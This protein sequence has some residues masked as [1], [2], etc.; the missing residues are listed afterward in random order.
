MN[1]AIAGDGAGQPLVTVL[2]AHLR[3]G[4]NDVEDLSPAT[5]NGEYYANTA[6]RVARDVLAGRYDRAILVCGTGIGVCISA[7]KVPG[8]RA[9]TVREHPILT[10]DR[11]DL[12]EQ[13]RRC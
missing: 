13:G 11:L 10:Q 3:D 4:A 8:I 1:I 6:A 9:A 7:N 12:I 5:A 2:A